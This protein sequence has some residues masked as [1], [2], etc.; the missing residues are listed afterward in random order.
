MTRERKSPSQRAEEQLAT[1]E[2]AVKR[3]GK[4]LDHLEAELDDV[5]DEHAEAVRRRDYLAAHPDLPKNAPTATT[6]PTGERSA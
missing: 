2:R 4:K 5:K 1:A 6:T 3:L